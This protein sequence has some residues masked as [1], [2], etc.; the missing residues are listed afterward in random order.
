M[1]EVTH[2]TRR[3]VLAGAFAA[4][5]SGGLPKAEAAGPRAIRETE[6]RALFNALETAQ[7]DRFLGYMR[8]LSA[9]EIGQ[10]PRLTWPAEEQSRMRA[11]GLM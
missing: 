6:F 7:R 11:A 3:A 10:D 5:I 2:S 4:G 8:W 1:A 9:G